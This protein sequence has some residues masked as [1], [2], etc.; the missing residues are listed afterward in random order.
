M[1][2]SS[3]V[4]ISPALLQ[5]DCY[6]KKVHTVREDDQ[7]KGW[8]FQNRRSLQSRRGSHTYLASILCGR[9]LCTL[10]KKKEV[11]S[12]QLCSPSVCLSVVNIAKC[13]KRI[14]LLQVDG[15]FDPPVKGVPVAGPT[16]WAW[17][18]NIERCFHPHLHIVGVC[19]IGVVSQYLRAPYLVIDIKPQFASLCSD[20]IC[21]IIE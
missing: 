6:L 20:H 17:L 12:S 16:T 2:A 13:N 11:W 18:C 5:L 15:Q 4:C 10:R 21:E 8:F 1:N 14:S 7:E 3:I 9:T 19:I